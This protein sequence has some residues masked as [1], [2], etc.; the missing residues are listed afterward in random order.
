MIGGLERREAL[1][2][3]VNEKLQ[4]QQT[5]H[6]AGRVKKVSLT[7]AVN[8]NLTASVCFAKARLSNGHV[9]PGSPLLLPGQNRCQV[10]KGGT[11]VEGVASSTPHDMHIPLHKLSR[12]AGVFCSRISR[13][14][15]SPEDGCKCEQPGAQVF[16]SSPTHGLDDSSLVMA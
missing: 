16:M 10:N 7:G 3:L 5:I 2:L 8:S 11:H 4:S 12:A 9:V 1:I 15:L 13:M 6:H 14:T